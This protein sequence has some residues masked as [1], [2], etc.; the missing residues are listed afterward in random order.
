MC[1]ML[2][3]VRRGRVHFGDQGRRLVEMAMVAPIIL[4]FWLVRRVSGPR[5]SGLMLVV[6]VVSIHVDLVQGGLIAAVRHVSRLPHL[7]LLRKCTQTTHTHKPCAA[8]NTYGASEYWSV[9]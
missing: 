3:M 1:L 8:T 2:M 9:R 7:D 5:W 6:V 4:I